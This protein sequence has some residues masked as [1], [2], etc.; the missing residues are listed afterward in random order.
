MSEPHKVS[1]PDPRSW[2]DLYRELQAK[3]EEIERLKALADQRTSDLEAVLTAG[4]REAER[5]QAEVARL[6]AELEQARQTPEHT[7]LHGPP[8]S[9]GPATYP[10]LRRVLS[11]TIAAKEQAERA[12]EQARQEVLE[13]AAG[14]LINEPSLSNEVARFVSDRLRRLRE[15]R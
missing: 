14:V 8:M 3:A 10:Q 15:G 9:K 2:L 4:E 12:L 7:D 1:P 11:E 6:R 5:L 13:E